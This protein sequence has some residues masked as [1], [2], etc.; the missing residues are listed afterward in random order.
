M[1]DTLS[2]SRITVKQRENSIKKCKRDLILKMSKI[3]S[4]FIDILCVIIL[5]LI[6]NKKIKKLWFILQ[7]LENVTLQIIEIEKTSLREKEKKK[8]KEQKKKK[9]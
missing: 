9:K 4:L 1:Q 6:D 5:S 2:I 7:Q 3:V 8:K